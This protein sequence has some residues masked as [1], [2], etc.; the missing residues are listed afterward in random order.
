MVAAVRR[1][2][3]LRAVA[4]QF[5]VGRGH[6]GPLGRAG[7][8]PAAGPGGLGPIARVPRT[9]PAA[10]RPPW[11]IWCCRR[12][13]EL[14]QG[15]LGAIGAE[16]I[17]Q[18]LVDQGVAKVPSVRTINRILGSPRRAGRP[19][20]T[21][22]PAAAHGLVSARRRRRPRPSWTASTSSRGWSSRAAPTSRC[23]TACPC[24]A[25]WSSPGRSTSPV[26]AATDRRVAWSSTGGRSACPA[27]PSSTTT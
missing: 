16:A 26:T 2:Q 17:R 18:A 27:T 3:S 23:S 20:R 6:G 14:A 11:R 21:R 24:T 10:R 15:D 8:R 1:G 5:G 22:R 19:K 4:E 12:G 7:Q 25:A 9:R 13:N